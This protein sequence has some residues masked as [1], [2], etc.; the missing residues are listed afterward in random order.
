MAS[1]KALVVCCELSSEPLRNLFYLVDS[2][3]FH[4]VS[5]KWT[6]SIK[7]NLQ[8]KSI[9]LFSINWQIACY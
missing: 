4:F 1:R 7:L 5:V 3:T 6:S 9:L 8:S 2:V